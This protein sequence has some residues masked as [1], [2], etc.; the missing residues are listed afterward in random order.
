[1]LEVVALAVVPV[2]STT[3]SIGLDVAAPEYSWQEISLEAL[4]VELKVA[5]TLRPDPPF[6]LAAYQI[7]CL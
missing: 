5:V 2:V 6:V 1:M 7:S 3:W 4:N